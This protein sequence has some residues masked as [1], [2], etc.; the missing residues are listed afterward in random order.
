MRHCGAQPQ[1]KMRALTALGRRFTAPSMMD[2]RLTPLPLGPSNHVWSEEGIIM[3]NLFRSKKKE[4]DAALARRGESTLVDP[5]EVM[6]SFFREPPG[7]IVDLWG[8]AQPYVPPVELKE[9]GDAYVLTIDLPGVRDEDIEVQVLENRLFITGKRE[10]E[11]IHEGEKFH[12]F[13]REYGAFSRSFTLPMD[14]DSEKVIATLE[15][16]VLHVSV[17]KMKQSHP[18]R[19][20][21]QTTKTG[22]ERKE[23]QGEEKKTEE[24]KAQESTA[25]KEPSPGKEEQKAPSKEEKKAA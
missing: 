5:F 16:G 7:E 11:E 15:N 9:T 4:P 18:K 19:I 1:S 3:A 2:R 12:A 23:G 22:E 21:I 20:S 17:P 6:R 25:K 10:H 13:E 24:G 14:T 8:A